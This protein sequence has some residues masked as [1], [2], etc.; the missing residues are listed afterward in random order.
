[1]GEAQGQQRFRS[2]TWQFRKRLTRETKT[3]EVVEVSWKGLA[4]L[5]W[6]GGGRPGRARRLW[7]AS[8]RLLGL[9]EPHPDAHRS[10]AR[11]GRGGTSPAECPPS[12][13]GPKAR[14][15]PALPGPGLSPQL[16]GDSAGSTAGTGLGEL[17]WRAN[18]AGWPRSAEGGVPEAPPTSAALSQSGVWA[19]RGAGSSGTDPLRSLLSS[20]TQRGCLATSEL[21]LFNA[22]LYPLFRA[23]LLHSRP[24][25]YHRDAEPPAFL[26]RARAGAPAGAASG[27]QLPARVSRGWRE[28]GSSGPAA[29]C[30]LCPGARG[31]RD[32]CRRRPGTF[33]GQGAG[34]G[35]LLNV[36]EYA[37]PEPD[38]IPARTGFRPS[39]GD[40]R[41]REW[42]KH[43]SQ[44]VTGTGRNGAGRQ[45]SLLGADCQRT[46]LKA[47]ALSRD[48]EN[49]KRPFYKDLGTTFQARGAE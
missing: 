5:T 11:E 10:P 47:G 14:P 1:M 9:G 34:G 45:W 22:P 30:G 8:S 21:V 49:D 23:G 7:P 42:H 15:R 37:M 6:L 40:R 18:L 39:E 3:A 28:A 46:P 31:L 32:T 19:G 44:V 27:F 4:R 17:V 13:S 38:G 20:P 16:G 35:S 2:G 36:E 41:A 33:R 26:E 29:S 24:W 43:C 12:R 48:L 25:A